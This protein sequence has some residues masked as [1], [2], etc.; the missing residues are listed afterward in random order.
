MSIEGRSATD[1]EDDATKGFRKLI[2]DTGAHWMPSKSA[3]PSFGSFTFSMAWF[4]LGYPTRI[5]GWWVCVVDI[6]GMH[7]SLGLENF[8]AAGADICSFGLW[9]SDPTWGGIVFRKYILVSI[10]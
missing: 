2:Q 9:N 4:N 1:V 7:V 10:W 8:K 3:G 6:H 5:S